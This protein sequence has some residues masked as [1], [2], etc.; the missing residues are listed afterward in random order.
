MRSFVKQTIKRAA[1]V[2]LGWLPRSAR[3]ITGALAIDG[4]RA[5]RDTRLR[6]WP[7]FLAAGTLGRVLT[8]R[9]HLWQVWL[10]GV[11]GLPQ[12]LA[13]RFAERWAEAVGA[14]YALLLPHCTDALRFGLAAALEHDGLDYGGE[15]LVPNL[16]FV[17][18]A[19]TALDRRC[20]V[21]LVDV[22]PD[23]LLLDPARCAEAIVPGRTRAI[24]PVHLFGQPANMTA[25]RVLAEQYGLKIIEDAAQAHDAAWEGRPV[26]SFG[27]CAGFSFQTHKNLAAGEG[28]V[29][30][31]NDEE[32]FE[33]AYELHNVGRRRQGGSRWEHVSLGWNCRPSEYQAA[34][35]LDR[36]P[37]FAELQTRRRENFFLLQQLLA[38]AQVV[39]PLAVRPQVTRHAA[40]MFS[41][42]YQPQ[43]AGGR[44]IDDFLQ[45]CVAEGAPLFRGFECPLSAQ[46]ALAKLRE[47]HPEY[48]RVLPTPVADAAAQQ[49]LYIPHQVFLT[50]AGDMRDIADALFKVERHFASR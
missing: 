46:P 15:V 5:V 6:P 34:V 30:T 29:L 3:R 25:L 41:L 42:L 23:T 39:R 28:G 9:S 1:Q 24:M 36:L 12:P 20:G 43:Q 19:T 4:G 22:E 48:V 13:Q 21:A 16:S 37:E 26:G 8:F 47:K 10:S 17:A 27:A 38:S 45:A 7:G 40:Y 35:L 49:L 18:S 50:T 14:R 44:S 2:G 11:E 33:R 32:L 31:T